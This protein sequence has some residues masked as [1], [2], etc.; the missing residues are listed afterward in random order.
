MRI[1]S[2]VDKAGSEETCLNLNSV[3]PKHIYFKHYNS[4][5]P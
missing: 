1:T 5:C 2:A 3:F 4:H